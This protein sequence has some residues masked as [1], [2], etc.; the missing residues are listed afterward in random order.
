MPR[1]AVQAAGCRTPCHTQIGQALAACWRPAGNNGNSSAQ[2]LR[3]CDL[4]EAAHR[5]FCV[6][7]V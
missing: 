6:V 3:R 4:T 2:P 1:A 7:D 5:A